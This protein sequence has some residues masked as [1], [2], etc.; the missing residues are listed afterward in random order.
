LQS[1][2]EQNKLH[3][4]QWTRRS[5][6][7]RALAGTAVGV[8]ARALEGASEAEGNSQTGFI[9]GDLHAMEATA[10]AFMQKSHLPGMS[11]AIARKTKM[12]SARFL[13]CS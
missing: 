8:V 12:R 11:V 6:C 7:A 2:A 13:R 9:L 3:P 10:A 1:R 4:V 5:F